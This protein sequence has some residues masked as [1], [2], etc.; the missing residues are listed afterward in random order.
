[1]AGQLVSYFFLVIFSNYLSLIAADKWTKYESPHDEDKQWS[2]KSFYRQLGIQKLA[3]DVSSKMVDCWNKAASYNN[4]ER[5]LANLKAEPLNPIVL[6]SFISNTTLPGI[7]VL[8]MHVKNG[9]IIIYKMVMGFT[10]EKCDKFMGPEGRH[11]FTPNFVVESGNQAVDFKAILHNH[12]SILIDLLKKHIYSG[13]SCLFNVSLFVFVFH[14][15][16]LSDISKHSSFMATR[17]FFHVRST[18]R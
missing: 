16:I 5:D 13:S 7:Y 4:L 2:F 1:M 14:L 11:R 6:A 12:L 3:E 17:Q 8:S 18:L 9:W 10:K 15:M